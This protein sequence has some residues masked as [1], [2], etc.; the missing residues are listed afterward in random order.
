MSAISTDA[1]DLLL[2]LQALPLVGELESKDYRVKLE[3][4]RCLDDVRFHEVD[5]VTDSMQDEEHRPPPIVL[6][7]YVSVL[8][9]ERLKSPKLEA[10]LH[11]DYLC[12]LQSQGLCGVAMSEGSD[13]HHQTVAN[14]NDL[15]GEPLDIVLVV[16]QGIVLVSV[17]VKSVVLEAKLALQINEGEIK[18]NSQNER[19]KKSDLNVHDEF[20]LEY[21]LHVLVVQ[22]IQNQE[23]LLIQDRANEEE[24]LHDTQQ[25]QHKLVLRRCKHIPQ[26]IRDDQRGV[27][28]PHENQHLVGAILLLDLVMCLH[29]IVYFESE[30]TDY[31]EGNVIDDM[32]LAFAETI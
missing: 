17:F 11:E 9:P 8:I 25:P 5:H 31:Q 22:R 10:S 20:H 29:I 14:G 4:D 7:S 30:Y 1:V 13:K 28:D 19:V 32:P 21:K 3:N 18:T 6:L 16:V 2:L 23:V 12:E 26:E 24:D 15:E 27:H